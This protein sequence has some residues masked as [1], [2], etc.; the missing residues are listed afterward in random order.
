MTMVD[1]SRYRQILKA[2]LYLYTHKELAIPLSEL[3][4][5]LKIPR[6]VILKYA[7]DIEEKGLIELRDE[8]IFPK[9]T[10]LEL[11]Y[12]TIA[13]GAD[14]E[15]IS[16][17][18][19][20]REFEGLTARCLEVNAFEIIEHF[21]FKANRR[22]YEVDIVGLHEPLILLIDCKHWGVSRSKRWKLKKA[23]ETH[24]SRAEAFAD[25]L[26][27]MTSLLGI[28]EWREAII[29]PILV[30]LHQELVIMYNQVPLVPVYKLNNFLQDLWSWL[31]CIYSRKVRLLTLL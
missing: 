22:K 6:S 19:D 23:V 24:I 5:I 28:K 7:R 16:E 14:I 21:I 11:A 25:N 27:H 12:A 9:V 17:I 4:A 30:T 1:E 18:L 8:L 31:D 26:M 3:S 15:E 29:I 2:L 10:R 13:L 20:W